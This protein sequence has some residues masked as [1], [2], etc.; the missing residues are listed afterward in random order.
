M[1]Y[2]SVDRK[3]F[4]FLWRLQCCERFQLLQV[5]QVAKALALVLQQ[6]LDP[7]KSQT[8]ERRQFTV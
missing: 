8:S 3:S 1:S 5:R 6:R 4:A 2:G 7:A